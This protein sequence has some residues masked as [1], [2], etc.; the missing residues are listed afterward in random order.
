MGVLAL[1]KSDGKKGEAAGSTNTAMFACRFRSMRFFIHM[2]TCADWLMNWSLRRKSQGGLMSH[3][4]WRHNINNEPYCRHLEKMGKWVCVCC[5]VF[6]RF[7]SLFPFFPR[8]SFLPSPSLSGAVFWRSLQADHELFKRWASKLHKLP[9]I[10]LAQ[11]LRDEPISHTSLAS[12]DKA[13]K[14]SS[15]FFS[16][17]LPRSEL[18]HKEQRVALRPTC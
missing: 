10:Y 18:R 9:R 11:N 16:D 15:L 2:H 6:S 13:S 3:Q 17:I 4:E 7:I 1:P 14:S 5:V 8:L 12:E